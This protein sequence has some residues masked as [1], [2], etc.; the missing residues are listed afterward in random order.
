MLEE[1][2]ERIRRIIDLIS[3]EELNENEHLSTYIEE[4]KEQIGLEEDHDR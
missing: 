1:I 3:D 2:Q 4:M